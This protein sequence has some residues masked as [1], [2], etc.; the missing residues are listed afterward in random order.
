MIAKDKQYTK[1]EA[2]EGYWRD[3]K[4]RYIPIEMIKPI[5]RLRDEL[6]GRI[7]EPALAITETLKEFKSFSFGETDAFR[8]LS[9]EQYNAPIGGE[10]GN[11][12]FHSFDGEYRIQVAIHDR[13]SFDERLKTAKT[14]IDECIM[15]WS[16]GSRPEI[17]A[18]I[19]DA[20]RTDKEGKIRQ[21]D[22]L[23]LR[24]LDITHEK[25]LRAM[26]AISESIKV[27][28]SCRYIRIYK[29]TGDNNKYDQIP[30]NITGV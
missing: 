7:I 23:N 27:I 19:N 6:V 26:D 12:T 15:E 8:A 28:D 16:E 5:D 21:Q 3:A 24:N 2:P 14:L 22:V 11:V 29:R 25:W 18:I 10:K 4:G 9:A 30:L 20:F 13:I 1:H 17:M